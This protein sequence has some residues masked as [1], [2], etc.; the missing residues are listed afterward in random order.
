MP[1][2]LLRFNQTRESL[3]RTLEV[4]RW[5]IKVSEVYYPDAL[6]GSLRTNDVSY[7]GAINVVALST[8][9]H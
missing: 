2:S 8:E 7:D 4:A 3:V 1:E 5:A 9:C 6:S